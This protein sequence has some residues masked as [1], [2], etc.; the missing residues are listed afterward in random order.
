MVLEKPASGDVW[1]TV[2]GRCWRSVAEVKVEMCPGAVLTRVRGVGGH[3]P[4]GT[5]DRI[6]DFNLE[7]VYIMIIAFV[8]HEPLRRGASA[9]PQQWVGL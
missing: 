3:L 5:D 2:A 8:H 9:L 6:C 1:I 4:P 7:C